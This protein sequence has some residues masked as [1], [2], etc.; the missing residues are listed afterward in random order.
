MYGMNEGGNKQENGPSA[1][2]AERNCGC[3]SLV[4]TR[5]PFSRS[6]EGTTVLPPAHP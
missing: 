2:E 5:N 3:Q 6:N 4:S 1:G